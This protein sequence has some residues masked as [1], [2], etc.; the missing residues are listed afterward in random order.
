MKPKPLLTTKEAAEYL[1]EL[2]YKVSERTLQHWRTNRTG[3]PYLMRGR[4][5][6]Y[7][8]DQINQWLTTNL[9][10]VNPEK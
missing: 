1:T 6:L 3:L 7:H 10:K 5:I 8:R 9:E 4:R 2:G